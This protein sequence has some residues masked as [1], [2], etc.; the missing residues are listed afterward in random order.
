MQEL[1]TLSPEDK[2]KLLQA[3][4]YISLL[5]ANVDGQMDE[6]EKYEAIKFSHIKTY[7]AHKLLKP[8]Y[9]EVEKHFIENVDSLNNSLPK[10]KEEREKAIQAELHTVNEIIGKLDLFTS[11]TIRK[12]LKEY[13][14]HV[15][16]AHKN[17][18]DDFVFPFAIKGLT[19]TTHKN[20]IE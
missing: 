14:D 6:E 17:I 5:A 18:M 15:S 10:Q 16:K 9:Q 8:F 1:E 12:S 3:P 11:N 20:K 7:T 2:K 19:D 4:A 13:A